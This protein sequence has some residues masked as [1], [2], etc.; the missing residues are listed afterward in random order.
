MGHSGRK[1]ENQNAERNLHHEI[2]KGILRT[3]LGTGLEAIHI[4]FWQSIS[5]SC[6]FP[7]KTS[8]AELKNNGLSCLVRKFLQHNIQDVAW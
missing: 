7:E 8:E 6:P 4:A 2:F 5:A 1:L 3:L